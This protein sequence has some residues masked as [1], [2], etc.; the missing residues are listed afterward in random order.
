MSQC[1]GMKGYTQTE[2]LQQKGQIQ[3]LV[4]KVQKDNIRID[5]CRNTWDSYFMQKE[6][7]N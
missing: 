7:E 1:Y 2:K 3:I 5:S 4:L 6:R